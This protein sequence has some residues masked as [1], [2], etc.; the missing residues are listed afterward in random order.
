MAVSVDRGRVGYKTTIKRN[1]LNTG[2]PQAKKPKTLGKLD[3]LYDY[4][5]KWLLMSH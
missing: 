4:M 1:L 2:I 5:T 3:I